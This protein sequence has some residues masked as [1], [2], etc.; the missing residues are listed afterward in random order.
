MHVV[1]WNSEKYQSIAEALDH[2]DGLAV[3]GVLFEIST[4]DNLDLDPIIFAIPEVS[5]PGKSKLSC[6]GY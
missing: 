2:A 3:L 4:D 1:N 6:Y 5:D